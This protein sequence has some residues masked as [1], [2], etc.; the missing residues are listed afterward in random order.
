MKS[1]EYLR[2]VG[3]RFYHRKLKKF[4]SVESIHYSTKRVYEFN[5]SNIYSFNAA[6]GTVEWVR[7]TFS[8]DKDGE[9]IYEHDIVE[10]NGVKA[11]VVWSPDNNCFMLT[12][13]DIQ[14][15]LFIDN[16]KL[17]KVVGTSYA[18]N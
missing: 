10:G 4:I 7:P 12:D 2:W 3:S 6:N 13:D 5:T 8:F 14:D 15:E 17:Y 18:I 9:M 11:E 1:N 16:S